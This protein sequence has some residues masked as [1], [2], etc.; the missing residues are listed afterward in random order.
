MSNHKS[1]ALVAINARSSHTNLALYSMEKVLSVD[2]SIST[3]LFEF[4]INTNWLEILAQL[5]DSSWDYYLFSA[6]IWN[7]E[8]LA[9]VIPLLKKLASESVIIVGGPSAAYDGAAL[10]KFAG[11]DL[12][13]LGQGEAFVKEFFLE[14]EGSDVKFHAVYQ[15]RE[16]L[17]LD[18]IAFPYRQQMEPFLRDR[19]LYYETSRGCR[20]SCAYCLSSAQQEILDFRSLELVR[21]ELPQLVSLNPKIIKLV[22]RTFN[23]SPERARAIWEMI[24]SLDSDVPFHFELHPGLLT[25]DDFSLLERVPSGLFFIEVGIQSTDTEVLKKVNRAGNWDSIR[26]SVAR[27]CSMK[28][29]HIHVDQIVGLPGDDFQTA[30]QSFDQILALKPDEFQLGFLKLLPGT[31]SA[32][33]AD[34]YDMVAADFPPFQV[35]AT[36]TLSFEQMKI[37]VKVEELLDNFYN[38]K[39]FKTTFDWLLS[40]KDGWT[41]FTS[42]IQEKISGKSSRQWKPL[43]ERLFIYL[44]EEFDGKKEFI[45]D[46][47]VY[48]WAS[49]A[50][51]Q[52]VPEFLAREIDANIRDF[53]QQI[54]RKFPEIDK[55]SFNHSFVYRA[56][57]SEMINLLGSSVVIFLWQKKGEK[58][59]IFC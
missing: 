34:E 18:D 46:L 29:L 38:S 13:V 11:A 55:S 21:E 10:S 59:K 33:E 24:L 43:A 28:N 37:F 19:L 7:Q 57:T 52:Q 20:Y 16:P 58:T 35:V 17:R 40:Q 41:I 39:Y 45:T 36:S 53:R 2:S 22:D 30:S 4:E 3:Q 8:L 49:I 32:R 27:L 50:P 25:E 15:V 23:H 6:Y 51:S 44:I 31:K 14:G 42:L 12:V 1:I 26:E 56:Q 5:T 9:K 54:S 47:L 48:D